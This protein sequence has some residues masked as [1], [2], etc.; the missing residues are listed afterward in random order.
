MSLSQELSWPLST[1]SGRLFEQRRPNPLSPCATLP[2]A[3]FAARLY[4]PPY[5]TGYNVLRQVV[6]SSYQGCVLPGQATIEHLKGGRAEEKLLKQ[7]QV[8]GVQSKEVAQVKETQPR[9]T[10]EYA[11]LSSWMH[12]WR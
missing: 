11:D 12:M 6:N 10:S 1:P 9:K 7:T 3:F 5:A 4:A 2:V 8:K